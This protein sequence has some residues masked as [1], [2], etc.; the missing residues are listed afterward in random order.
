MPIMPGFRHA[1]KLIRVVLFSTIALLL[2]VFYGPFVSFSGQG[3]RSKS[4]P[5]RPEQSLDVPNRILQD[6]HVNFNPPSQTRYSKDQSNIALKTSTAEHFH[7]HRIQNSLVKRDDEERDGAVDFDQAKCKGQELLARYQ[8]VLDN[9]G[10]FP[11]VF[12]FSA[13][14]NG[15]T[16]ENYESDI[17][18]A[19]QTYFDKQLG[20]GKIP[21]KDQIR[22]ITADQDLDFINSQGV[23]TE[24]SLQ[25]KEL[26]I[27]YN[28][29]TQSKTASCRTSRLW[30]L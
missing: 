9:N 14:D 21:P 26:T 16:L 10:P 22:F 8:S 13:L 6:T 19:W 20:K 23:E 15:W 2:S 24:V 17:G 28:M 11:Q 27:S 18:N 1:H 12:P 29:L 30:H 5:L 3:L 25:H 7:K 4:L